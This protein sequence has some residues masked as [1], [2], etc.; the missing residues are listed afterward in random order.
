[1]SNIPKHTKM[2]MWDRRILVVR[3]MYSTLMPATKTITI[4]Q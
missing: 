3:R 4:T 1:M 2:T